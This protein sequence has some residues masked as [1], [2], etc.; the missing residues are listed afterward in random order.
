MYWIA[1][2]LAIRPS[3][4]PLDGW[5]YATVAMIYIYV[6]GYGLGWSSVAWATS[7]EVVSRVRSEHLGLRRL[8]NV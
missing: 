4:V 6:T 2:F 5:S 1:I 3:G 8:I 7:S